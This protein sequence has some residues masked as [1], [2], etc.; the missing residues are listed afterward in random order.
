MGRRWVLRDDDTPRQR[1]LAT[2]RLPALP[3]S[4][5]AASVGAIR[6]VSAA[7]VSVTALPRRGPVGTQARA[8]LVIS[9][10]SASVGIAIW[11]GNFQRADL[12]IAHSTT[13]APKRD[14]P[15]NHEQN[16]C[17]YF[18]N[19]VPGIKRGFGGDRPAALVG[20]R[21][22]IDIALC[23]WP[24]IP[25]VRRDDGSLRIACSRT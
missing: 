5:L 19:C 20:E 4:A 22:G 14:S 3:T 17:G 1:C 9:R 24:A 18:V 7:V 10:G 21:V 16:G 23:G 12:E 15:I 13:P 11:Y 8:I 25:V 2:N 6:T